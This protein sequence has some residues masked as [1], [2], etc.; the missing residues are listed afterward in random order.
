MNVALL[1]AT[2]SVIGAL[3]VASLTYIFTRRREHEAD[4]RKMKLDHYR[5]YIAALSGVVHSG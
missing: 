2:T 1:T 4:W 3:A 5:E